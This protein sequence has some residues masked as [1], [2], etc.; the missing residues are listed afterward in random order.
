MGRCRGRC[1][2]LQQPAHSTD[3]SVPRQPRGLLLFAGPAPVSRT[4]AGVR[5]LA[6]VGLGGCLARGPACR[7]S[8]HSPALR[9]RCPRAPIR[10][11]ARL[12]PPPSAANGPP[13]VWPQRY[14]VRVGVTPGLHGAVEGDRAP[15]PP[16]FTPAPRPQPRRRVGFP[17]SPREGSQLGL[18][19][20]KRPWRGRRRPKEEP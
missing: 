7:R 12:P 1:Q 5:D 4:G 2:G 16:R 13:W 6:R 18:H 3:A 10:L 15:L 20:V 17:P 8:L 14:C 9:P 11:P 19:L